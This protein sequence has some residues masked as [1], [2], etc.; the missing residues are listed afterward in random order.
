M[1]VPVQEATAVFSLESSL[2]KHQVCNLAQVISA[3][4]I[5]CVSTL[6]IGRQR[7]FGLCAEQRGKQGRPF[8]E[9]CRG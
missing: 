7:S 2:L 3:D 1:V 6:K 8:A 4:E 9:L 5:I